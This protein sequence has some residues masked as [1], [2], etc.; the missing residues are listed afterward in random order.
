MIKMAD[1]QIVFGVKL[2]TSSAAAE[3]AILRTTI[4]A[5][6]TVVST[7]TTAMAKVMGAA[8]SSA[9]S[10]ASASASAMCAAMTSGGMSAAGAMGSLA[11]SIGSA[12]TEISRLCAVNTTGV[13]QMLDK[14]NELSLTK[15][16]GM[17]SSVH[18]LTSALHSYIA[19]ASAANA[20]SL[21]TGS[22][23]TSSGSSGVVS[24]VK[25]IGS[26]LKS[27]FKL[28]S[29]KDY[30]PYD[31][32][33]ALLHKGEAVLTASENEALRNLGGAEG[34]AGL[35]AAGQ[36]A[37]TVENKVE[38]SNPTPAPQNINL[39]VELDGYRVAKAVGRAT[40]ELSRQLNT[41]IIRQ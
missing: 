34:I 1:G 29:G 33:P 3:M 24:T 26:A 14:L 8:I 28:R 36:S 16:T 7:V 38:V 4:T 2:D 19:A 23:R 6:M 31:D 9:F 13:S 20:V 39:S 12:G 15:I 30:I 18:S 17:I 41:R 11:A 5:G 10:S 40:D 25:N 27:A 35:A 22:A 21:T 32:Y 37:V